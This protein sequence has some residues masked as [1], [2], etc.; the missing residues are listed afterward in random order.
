M[1]VGGKQYFDLG[2]LSEIG[3]RGLHSVLQQNCNDSLTEKFL[4]VMTLI[5]L[6]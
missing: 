3:C 1:C 4:F 2:T 5:L 6:R